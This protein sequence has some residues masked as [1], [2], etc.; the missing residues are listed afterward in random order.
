MATTGS[1]E[2]CLLKERLV[3]FVVKEVK[4][5]MTYLPREGKPDKHNQGE[6]TERLRKKY[7]IFEVQNGPSLHHFSLRR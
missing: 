2:G 3:R 6:D 7:C 4:P 5:S 1:N